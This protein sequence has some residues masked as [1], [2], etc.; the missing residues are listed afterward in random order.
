G[1]VQRNEGNRF[2]LRAG[3]VLDDEIEMVGD[4]VVDDEGFAG[5]VRS[6]EQVRS[7]VTRALLIRTGR[8]EALREGAD[9]PGEAA[10]R[11]E[12]RGGLQRHPGLREASGL[13]EMRIAGVV[14]RVGGENDMALDPLVLDGELDRRGWAWRDADVR[15]LVRGRTH[16]PRR[17]VELGAL[18]RT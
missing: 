5:H 17:A 9:A 12:K 4:V 8:S 18:E 6:P 3:A 11:S 10:A 15:P 14:E 7:V 13:V 1:I 2:D 16:H